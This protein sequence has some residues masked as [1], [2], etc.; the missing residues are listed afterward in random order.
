MKYG[1]DLGHNVG[2]DTGASGIRQEDELIRDT[3]YKV[4][5]KLRT[6]GHTAVECTPD[7]AASLGDS[8]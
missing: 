5:N 3:G 1:V 8:L 7:S 4:I 2:A 6:M